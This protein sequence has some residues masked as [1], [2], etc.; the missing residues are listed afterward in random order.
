M[1]EQATTPAWRIWRDRDVLSAIALILISVWVFFASGSLEAR[2]QLDIGPDFMPR[3]LAVLM[4][5]L[6]LVQLTGALRRRLPPRGSRIPRSGDFVERNADYLSLAAILGYV[7]L[8][9]PLGFIVATALFL[10]VQITIMAPRA[11]RRYLR[12]AL[13]AI[14]VALLSFWFFERGFYVF[15]PEGILG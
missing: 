12:F 1:E 15:L 8:F 13:L 3:L 5:L 11:E 2:T 6:S 14:T 7:L 9:Q 10:F 4:F